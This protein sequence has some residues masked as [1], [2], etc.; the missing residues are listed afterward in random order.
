[1]KNIALKEVIVASLLTIIFMV[2]PVSVKA[3]YAY[4]IKLQTWDL[5][6][7]GKH[8]DW[9]GSSAYLT[10]FKTAAS[11]WNDHISGVIRQDSW[12]TVNDLTISDADKGP[13]GSVATT[14]RHGL[15]IFNTFYMKNL[16]NNE[17]LNVCLHE[18]GHALR[19]DHRDEDGTVMY[20]SVRSIT[21]LSAGDKANYTEAYNKYY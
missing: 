18:L 17:K 8:L 20:E 4:T 21:I 13:T 10:Q 19:L 5:V 14:Y 6:D 7:S 16:S 2:I 11:K 12:N 3:W 15:I 9:K 1:M